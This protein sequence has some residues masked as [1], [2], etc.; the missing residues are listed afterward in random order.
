MLHA[1]LAVRFSPREAIKAA[2]NETIPERVA[3]RLVAASCLHASAEQMVL[4][5][6]CCLWCLAWV[7]GRQGWR[8]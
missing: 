1:E 5:A 7:K 4:T 3:L 6:G 2:G 8:P